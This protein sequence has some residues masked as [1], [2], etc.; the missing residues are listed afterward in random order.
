[1]A[2]CTCIAQVRVARLGADCAPC[3]IFDV[4]SD[5]EVLMLPTYVHVCR[6]IVSATCHAAF[7]IA[8]DLESITVQQVNLAS[9]CVSHLATVSCPVLL[10]DTNDNDLCKTVDCLLHCCC[11]AS[12]SSM[13]DHLRPLERV[14]HTTSAAAT[15]TSATDESLLHRCD[16]RCGSAFPPACTH[17]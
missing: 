14:Q 6:R 7:G 8:H 12:K 11:F 13:S 3:C 1:M 9:T 15:S 17:N 16:L 2:K 10:Q 4:C 5:A